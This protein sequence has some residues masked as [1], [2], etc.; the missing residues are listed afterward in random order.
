MHAYLISFLLLTATVLV[1]ASTTNKNENSTY[2]ILPENHQ[3]VGGVDAIRGEFPFMASLQIYNG[4][5]FCGGSVVS[6]R[7]ILTAAHCVA[8]YSIHSI[9]V[10]KH[11][12]YSN[13]GTTVIR[14]KRQ[15]VHPQYDDYYTYNDVALLEL[16]SD[17]PTQFTSLSLA[18]EAI[19]S[20]Y[21]N[22]GMYTTVIGWGDTKGTGNQNILQKVNIPITSKRKCRNVGGIDS[23]ICAGLPEG[24]KDSCQ[25]D[26][27]GPLFVKNNDTVY[28]VGI[29]SFG[30]GCALPNRP[31]VYARIANFKPWIEQYTG[32]TD[33]SDPDPSDPAKECGLCSHYT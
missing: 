20:L 4:S 3:I 23:N 1:N 8:N 14:V 10:G 27:G 18:N 15:I 17:I 30:S 19:T 6:R 25:G 32:S 16:T 28:Q 31:G 26:S 13:Q 7:F 22:E 21:A 5:H 29:V 11:F 9:V 33:P 24:G 2:T 12:K